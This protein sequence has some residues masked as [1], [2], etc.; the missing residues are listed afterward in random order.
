MDVSTNLAVRELLARASYALDV[1][2]MDMLERCFAPSAILELAIEG[3]PEDLHFEG[4]DSIMGLM[5]QA[6]EEQTDVRRH[7]TTNVFFLSDSPERVQVVSNLTLTAV[8]GGEIRLICSGYY[9][10]EVALESGEWRIARRR[11]ELDLPY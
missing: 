8:E 5:R 11:I 10:D 2:D 6:A 1:R 7:V 4:R 9:K 3:A